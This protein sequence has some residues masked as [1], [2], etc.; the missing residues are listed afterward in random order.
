[1]EESHH[2]HHHRHHHHHGHA[3]SNS[4]EQEQS[5]TAPVQVPRP[6]EQTSGGVQ[7]ASSFHSVSSMDSSAEMAKYFP[8][9]QTPS[10]SPFS[11]QQQ[12]D[13]SH[14]TQ[15][16]ITSTQS[17][18]INNAGPYATVP[19]PAAVQPQL[20]QPARAAVVVPQQQ[21]AV[22]APVAPQLPAGIPG[23][24]SQIEG[25]SVSQ[26]IVNDVIIDLQTKVINETQQ[27][28][29]DEFSSGNH[30][31]PLHPIY[32]RAPNPSI[33]LRSDL[34]RLRA[35]L[36]ARPPAHHAGGINQFQ[37]PSFPPPQ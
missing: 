35:Q 3:D 4:S 10:L 31:E 11:R 7:A 23:Y 37:V 22:Q 18:A 12:D 32:I 8:D 34:H 16:E 36:N 20:P 6:N 30:L 14:Q 25:L 26:T 9:A 33:I 21:Q 29:Y 5:V 28:Y 27:Q 2:H 13:E 24:A 19:A 17:A 15:S 1:M